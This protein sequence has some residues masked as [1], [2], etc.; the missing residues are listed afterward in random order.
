[1][2]FFYRIINDG[3][4]YDEYDKEGYN[5]NGFDR[6]GFDRDGYDAKGFNWFG[7]SRQVENT[8]SYGRNGVGADQ[9]LT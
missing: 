8:N 3:F 6:K 7:F 1:M 2:G 5:R 4:D 9:L